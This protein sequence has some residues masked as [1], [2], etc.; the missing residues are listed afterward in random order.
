[1][2]S[3]QQ[4]SDARRQLR[5]FGAEVVRVIANPT[6]PDK[7]VRWRSGLATSNPRF[8]LKMPK[9]DGS[10]YAEGVA[11]A[12]VEQEPCHDPIDGRFLQ[13]LER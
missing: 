2:L 3:G 6:R 5:D 13:K 1:M 9:G 10:R 12:L 7:L 11:T 8:L 4:S